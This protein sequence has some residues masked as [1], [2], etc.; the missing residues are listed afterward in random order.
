MSC[1]VFFL[2]LICDLWCNE[3]RISFR[4]PFVFIKNASCNLCRTKGQISFKRDLTFQKRSACLFVLNLDWISFKIKGLIKG[5]NI[6]GHSRTL[7]LLP[8]KRLSR[9]FP[10]NCKG[11][12]ENYSQK[13]ERP[14]LNW[15]P[16]ADNRNPVSFR[17]KNL[18]E[19]FYVTL[20]NMDL[21]LRLQLSGCRK[22]NYYC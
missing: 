7:Q 19:I 4:S 20:K 3:E 10:A 9:G 21:F 12:G 13:M 16:P 17:E 8:L 11:N 14:H 1:C 2:V 22:A 6:G 18:L 5:V 15:R